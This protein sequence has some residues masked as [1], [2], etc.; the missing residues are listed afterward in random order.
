MC[1]N[2]VGGGDLV[3]FLAWFLVVLCGW[4]TLSGLAPGARLVK[5][6]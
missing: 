5:S 2:W 6:L 1:G 4:S 3:G